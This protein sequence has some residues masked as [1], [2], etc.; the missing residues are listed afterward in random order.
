MN[1]REFMV[2]LPIVGVSSYFLIRNLHSIDYHHALDIIKVVQRHIAPFK[3]INSF[4]FFNQTT[5]HSTFDPTKKS[6]LIEGAKKIYYQS[7]GD[8]IH[9]SNAIQE[10]F[11]EKFA[12]TR[13]GY[14]WMSEMINLCLEATFCDA[15]Y[16]E[17][18]KVFDNLEMKRGEPK[19]VK[20]YHLLLES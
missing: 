10:Q 13:Y 14:E 16:C 5:N 18:Q 17:N 3:S 9:S 11:L 20:K 1:R 7:G 19:P 12:Q 6:F 8:F 15:L 4:A 2:L